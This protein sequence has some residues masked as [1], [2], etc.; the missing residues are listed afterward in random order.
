MRVLQQHAA[1]GAAPRPHGAER[2]LVLLVLPEVRQGDLRRPVEPP[3]HGPARLDGVAEQRRVA[4][5]L[6]LLRQLPLARLEDAALAAAV[7]ARP[8]VVAP[9]AARRLDDHWGIIQKPQR[10]RGRRL[11]QPLRQALDA[12]HVE[13]EAEEGLGVRGVV[14][15]HR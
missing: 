9:R 1:L 7:P 8:A 4:P 14:G 12:V 6:Q 11:A 2:R 3:A 5:L 15:G 13:L 10:E